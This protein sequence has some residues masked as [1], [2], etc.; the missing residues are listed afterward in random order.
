MPRKVRP[1]PDLHPSD[2]TLVSFP[3]RPNSPDLP[4][5]P[6]PPRRYARTSTRR[7]CSEIL[8]LSPRQL[9]RLA[10]ISAVGA[11]I[12]TVLL[13]AALVLHIREGDDSRSPEPKTRSIT[14]DITVV[15][16][17]TKLPS[18]TAVLA[19]ELHMTVTAVDDVPKHFS[20]SVTTT[21]SVDQ[22]PS[23]AVNVSPSTGSSVAGAGVPVT[24][25]SASTEG[26]S[27]DRNSNVSE[28][29]TVSPRPPPRASE[30]C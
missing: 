18:S 23:I 24:V 2:I 22:V 21:K 10:L 1:L 20:G 5:P 13:L 26:T 9:R 29:T 11:L 12:S 8:G 14:I 15:S 25:R 7:T 17:T 4:P 6:L 27:W 19:T 16:S 28:A 30:C 3:P